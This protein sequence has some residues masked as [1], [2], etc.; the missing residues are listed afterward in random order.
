[1]A[2][3][4]NNSMESL[5]GRESGDFRL[6]QPVW[7]LRFDWEN[8]LES[9]LFPIIFSTSVYFLCLF[10]FTTFD[11][12][13]KNWGWIQKYKIQTDREVTN[14]QVKK[15]LNIT[16][17]NHLLYILPASI[18]QWIWVP[19]TPLPLAAPSLWEFFWQQCVAM[20]IFDFLVFIWHSIHHK[21][22]FLYRHVHSIHHHYSSPNSWATEYVHPCE[23]IT[24]GFFGRIAPKW[25]GPHPL[26][27]WS[28]LAFVVAASVES[29]CG[30]DLPLMPHRWA[31][32][33]GGSVHHDMHHLK[34]LTNFQ[35]F[36]TQFDRLF[37]TFCPGQRAGGRKPVALIEWEK[38]PRE[39]ETESVGI[40]DSE[41][42]KPKFS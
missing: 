16:A 4:A 13:G 5:L 38:V 21:V 42:I 1:M 9:P 28:F 30:Y 17:W 8:T 36:F 18:A 11:L 7:D 2:D 35:P 23:L 26:T 10:P 33:W 32:F 6:L 20:V 24:L 40:A 14:A 34:P 12:Y 15:A 22:R 37:G 29:H 39:C 19:S 27:E 41:R 25:F 3:Q 31:P